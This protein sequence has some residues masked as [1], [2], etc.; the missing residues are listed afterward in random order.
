[1]DSGV[2][3]FWVTNRY[4]DKGDRWDFYRLGPKLTQGVA[5]RVRPP[6]RTGEQP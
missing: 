1:L 4:R 6:Q 2:M 5:Q 3:V